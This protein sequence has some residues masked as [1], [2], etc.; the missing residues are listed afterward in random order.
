MGSN[1]PQATGH[2]SSN[3]RRRISDL[4]DRRDGEEASGIEQPWPG[5]CPQRGGESLGSPA[6]KA[7]VKVKV[8]APERING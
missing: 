5:A 8:K 3:S 7:Q 2:S 4:H 1:T 6:Y